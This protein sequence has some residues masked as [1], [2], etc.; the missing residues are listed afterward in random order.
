MVSPQV[1]AWNEILRAASFGKKEAPR[2]QRIHVKRTNTNWNR[3]IYQSQL[4]K[5]PSHQIPIEQVH[6]EHEVNWTNY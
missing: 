4:N 6:F 5:L 3:S 1:V 2:F